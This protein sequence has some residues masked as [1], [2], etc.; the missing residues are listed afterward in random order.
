MRIDALEIV[1]RVTFDGVRGVGRA[2]Q[3]VLEHEGRDAV[4]VEETRDVVPL[5]IRPQLAMAAARHH[6]DGHAG[7]FRSCGR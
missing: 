7:V 6:D 3:P 5:V 2:R 4:L 1:E